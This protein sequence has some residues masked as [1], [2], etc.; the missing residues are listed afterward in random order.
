M[1]S[2][3]ASSVP[4]IALQLARNPIVDKAGK[5]GHSKWDVRIWRYADSLF[6]TSSSDLSSLKEWLCGAAPLSPELMQ[7][8]VKR[9]KI[10]LFQGYGLSETSACA[11]VNR[12]SF[13]RDGSVG[14]PLPG[15][16]LRIVKLGGEDAQ[17]GEEGE[18]WVKGVNIVRAYHKNQKATDDTFTKD[19]WL[20]TG[21]VGIMKDGFL[22][23]VDR[24]K[25]LIKVKGKQCAPAEIEATL[26]DCELVADAAVIGGE[27]RIASLDSDLCHSHLTKNDTV[28]VYDESE[29]TEWPRAYGKGPA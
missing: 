28:A 10:P 27:R 25:E 23:I 24:L 11:T 20:M 18:V 26:L 21:D 4:P 1:L 12:P 7:D 16:Q 15:Q 5:C 14:K 6:Y 17:E 29:A 3:A 2:S 19:G 8:L 22:Y 9:T 13:N